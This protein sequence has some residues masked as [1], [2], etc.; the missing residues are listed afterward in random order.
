[1]SGAALVD[2]DWRGHHSNDV[3]ELRFENG[4]TLVVKQGRHDWVAGPFR[5]AQHASDLLRDEADV[6]APVLIDTPSDAGAPLQAYWRIPLPTLADVW[7]HLPEQRRLGT[8]RSLGRLVRRLHEITPQGWGPL[9]DPIPGPEGL[10]TELERD[11]VHRLLPAVR[12]LWPAGTPA[13]ERLIA[14]IPAVAER[15]GRRTAVLVHDD[16]HMMNVLCAPEDDET[17][18]DV[19]CVGFLDLDGVLGAP[20]ERDLAGFDVLHGPLFHQYL[21]PRW[22]S[23]VFQGYALDLDPGILAFYRA[24]HLANFGFHDALAGHHQH[25]DEVAAAFHEEVAGFVA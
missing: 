20:P 4:R 9:T 14:A 10:R 2:I 7:P 19:G 25:A 5:T 8:L 16:L 1:M 15:A 12:S 23:C 18:G 3:F 6:I 17:D 22:R 13:L 21:E 24:V 11:L